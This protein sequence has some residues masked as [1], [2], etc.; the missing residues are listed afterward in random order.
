MGSSRKPGYVETRLGW[1]HYVEEG[2]GPP[3]VMLHQTPRSADEFCELLPLVAVSHRAIAVDMPGFG[4][5]PPLPAPQT[6]EAFADGVVAFLDA[7]G[8]EA[9]TLLGHHTGAVVALEIAA[10]F[11]DRVRALVLSSM[12]F[13]DAESRQRRQAHAIPD[14]VEW[15]ED[16]DRVKALWE[17]RAPLFPPGRGDLLQRFVRD[18]I[19][20]GIDPA[21]GHRAVGRYHMEDRIPLV[22]APTL[23]IGATLDPA[24]PELP[25][26]QQ[27]LTAVSQVRTVV[28]E[29]GRLPLM[30]LNAPEVAAAVP[31]FLAEI[32]GEDTVTEEGRP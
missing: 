6:I 14:D 15:T 5:S 31:N 10:A 3:L 2:D 11:P 21:E 7:L 20:P 17:G 8:L 24:F 22:S 25:Q 30:E 19:A 1:T 18:A 16:G 26:V 27:A 23:L 4:S 12:G 29:G 28:V 32:F 13:V 9:V